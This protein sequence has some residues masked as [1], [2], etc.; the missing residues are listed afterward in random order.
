MAP[1]A[2]RYDRGARRAALG[3]DLDADRLA[4]IRCQVNKGVSEI[5]T[6][7]ENFAVNRAGGNDRVYLGLLDRVEVGFHVTIVANYTDVIKYKMEWVSR[8]L[9]ERRNVV[10]YVIPIN[11]QR[12]GELMDTP[13]ED[14]PCLNERQ[15]A[16]YFNVAAETVRLWRR[17]GVWPVF[18]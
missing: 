16:K 13:P 17:R 8:S 11:W 18:L 5:L 6:D 15:V 14:A 9:K 12:E 10:M 4:I 1:L 3:V 7:T 2:H